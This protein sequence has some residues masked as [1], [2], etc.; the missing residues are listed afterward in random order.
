MLV[1]FLLA[2]VVLG[3]VLG[4][5]P[6]MRS[7]VMFAG[8]VAILLLSPRLGSY[9]LA[10]DY[11]STPCD[12]IQPMTWDRP[13]V[14]PAKDLAGMIEQSGLDRVS[15]QHVALKVVSIKDIRQIESPDPDKI[16]C[17][18]IVETDQDNFVYVF[19]YLQ[20]HST[21][22]WS[23]HGFVAGMLEKTLPS[24]ITLDGIGPYTVGAVSSVNNYA[25]MTFDIPVCGIRDKTWGDTLRQKLLAAIP[26]DR[27]DL[28]KVAMDKLGY[29]EKYPIN[30][31]DCSAPDYWMDLDPRYGDQVIA[32]ERSVWEPFNLPR[33]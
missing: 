16:I 1:E 24:D 27:A 13:A 15:G 11:N 6:W 2:C 33:P 14:D 7:A 8:L 9:A 17:K 32:G 29:I 21:G 28:L 31:F 20:L 4:I 25:V 26:R 23:I 3:V 12:R 22:Q 19:W 18:A 30:K 5:R 10:A